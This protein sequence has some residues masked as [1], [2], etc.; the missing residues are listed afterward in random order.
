MDLMDPVDGREEREDAGRRIRH[1]ERLGGEGRR[2]LLRYYE[3]GRGVLGQRRFF[4]SLALRRA[5]ENQSEPTGL[6]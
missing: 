1:W 5:S 4:S 3:Q 2:A 6:G